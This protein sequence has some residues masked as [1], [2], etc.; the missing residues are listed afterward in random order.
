MKM[1]KQVAILY[2]DQIKK[3]C[4]KTGYYLMDYWL[5]DDLKFGDPPSPDSVRVLYLHH[6]GKRSLL[7]K[8]VS[9]LKKNQREASVALVGTM[10]AYGIYNEAEAT[11]WCKLLEMRNNPKDDTDFRAKVVD[12]CNAELK[13]IE[14]SD[15]LEFE[16]LTFNDFIA[17]WNKLLEQRKARRRRNES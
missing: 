7:E 4:N 6:E 9:D 12:W 2:Y 11:V 17:R 5:L 3:V 14:K 10:T 1:Q 15:E 8:K 13:K 16:P